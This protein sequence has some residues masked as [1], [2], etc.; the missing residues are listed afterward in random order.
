MEFKLAKD[1]KLFWLANKTWWEV[2][3]KPCFPSSHPDKYFSVRDEKGHELALI[4]DLKQLD[5][6][7]RHIVENYLSFKNFVFEVK[8]IYNIDED[9]G[10]RHF[11]VKTSKGD[12]CFQTPL[13]EWPMICEDGTVIIDDLHGEQY[14]IRDLDFGRKILE[15]YL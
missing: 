4:E 9:F 7:N 1:K 15:A 13:D 6:Q 11:E 5:E 10:L 3:L 12:R 14:Q 2:E 8:G